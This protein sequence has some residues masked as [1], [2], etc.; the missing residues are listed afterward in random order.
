MKYETEKALSVQAAK[1]ALALIFLAATTIAFTGCHGSPGVQRNGV[2]LSIP[3]DVTNLDPALSVDVDSGAILA[4]IH[5]GLVTFG[6]KGEILGDLASSWTI[7]DDQTAYTFSLDSSRTFS[8]NRK[9]TSADVKWSFDRLVNPATRSPRGWVLSRVRGYDEARTGTSSG[10]QGVEALD[11]ATVRITLDKPFAPFLSMIAM[12]NAYIIPAGHDP[13]SEETS[14]TATGAG[15]Y[16]LAG[17]ARDSR[18]DLAPRRKG[19]VP[20][21][22][23]I[24]PDNTTLVAE[25]R[26]GNI[27]MIRVPAGEI[28]FFRDNFGPRLRKIEKLDIYYLGFNNAAPPFSDPRVRMAACRAI[29]RGKILATYL[30]GAGTLATGPIPPGLKGKGQTADAWPYDPAAARKLLDDAG[31]TGPVKIELW[32]KT[33]NKDGDAILAIQQYLE[34]AGFKCSLIQV[35]WSALKDAV[36]NG[37][38]Q[39]FYMSWSADY[40]DAENF[41]YPLFHSSNWGSKGNRAK[42]SDSEVDRLLEAAI[43]ETDAD[44]RTAAYVEAEKRIVSLTPWVFLW[45]PMETYAFSERLTPFIPNPIYNADKGECYVLHEK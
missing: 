39:C 26:T 10:I 9:V 6:P 2:V 44:K 7:S 30:E 16:R 29:D 28:P 5:S 38:A 23:R 37:K 22:Y 25:F 27:D 31:F 21:S 1:S 4:K 3:S 20:I 35:D 33:G 14:E 24:I 12:V 40:P 17:W 41:L 36:N 11:P 8:D 34:V 32:Q 42:F 15:P 19:L 13:A 45:H 43:V 18:I